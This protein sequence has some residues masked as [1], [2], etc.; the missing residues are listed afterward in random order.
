MRPI[1]THDVVC[2]SACVQGTPVSLAGAVEPIKMTFDVANLCGAKEPGIQQGSSFPRVGG[3]AFWKA[4]VPIQCPL[5]STRRFGCARWR[6]CARRCSVYWVGLCLLVY[7][8]L[9]FVYYCLYLCSLP[10]YILVNKAVYNGDA[11]RRYHYRSN[12]LISTTRTWRS[13]VIS[14]SVTAASHFA[15]L[16]YNLYKQIT[17]TCN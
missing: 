12:S 13:R 1:A 2:L 7:F 11:I 5:K 10:V 9:C 17:V 8:Y 14:V 6:R 4:S 15:R 3:G 16:R